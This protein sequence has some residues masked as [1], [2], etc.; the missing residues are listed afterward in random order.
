M[1]AN[2]PICRWGIVS[3]GL[4]SSWFVE[5]LVLDRPDAKANHVIQCIGSSSLEKGKA[6]AA[7]YC[8]KASPT[9]YGTYEEVYNDPNVDCVYIGTPHSFHKKNCLDAIAAGKNV[10]CEKA[11]T[12]NAAEAREV[13]AAAEKKNVYVHEAMWLRH[14]PLVAEL[15]KLLFEDKVIGDVF[16][17]A[18]DFSLLIDIPNLPDTSRYKDLNLGAGTLLDLGI[19]PL[20]WSF[21]ALDPNTPEDSE[22]PKILATQTHLHGVEVTSSVLVQYPSSGRQG[23]VTSTT[24][25]GLRD[26]VVC[27]IQGTEGRVDVEGAAPALPL[28]FAVYRRKAGTKN[29]TKDDLDSKKYDYPQIGRGFIYEA[30]NTALDIAAGRKE[31]AIMPWKETLRVMEIMDEIRKQGGT[32]YPQDSSVRVLGGS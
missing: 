25:S 11:F 5:D 28:S 32:I 29:D 23:V 8:P 30:D 31:S 15:R 16:R 19:Y 6:F 26:P 20:T 24:M 22:R 14:R 4:I 3:T 7:K 10:L 12:I 17:M 13:F 2:V 1:A 21:L 9:V 27:R 18:S